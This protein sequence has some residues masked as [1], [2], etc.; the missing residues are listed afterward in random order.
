MFEIGSK[1]LSFL[2]FCLFVCVFCVCVNIYQAKIV[3]VNSTWACFTSTNVVM[4]H[5][6]NAS[7][8]SAFFAFNSLCG[9][10]LTQAV[11]K[12][13]WCIAS[14][15]R[16]YWSSSWPAYKL[17]QPPL[18]LIMVMNLQTAWRRH[19]PVSL[20][21]TLHTKSCQNT[22]WGTNKIK[23]TPE[24]LKSLNAISGLFKRLDLPIE[25][26]LPIL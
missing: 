25:I 20:C 21:Y 7:S 5:E 26:V 19:S 17:F 16:H 9:H 4:S 1:L 12:F 14:M 2:N 8:H 11:W 24:T 22:F 10:E 3:R 18:M 13:A 23:V 6:S 15:W